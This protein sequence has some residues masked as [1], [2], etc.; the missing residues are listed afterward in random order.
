MKKISFSEYRKTHNLC[1]IMQVNNY[2]KTLR[3]YLKKWPRKWSNRNENINIRVKMRILNSMHGPIPVLL[4]RQR[5][6]IIPV[7]LKLIQQVVTA[8]ERY[9]DGPLHWRHNEPDGVSNHQPRDCLLNCLFRFRSKKKSKLRVTGLCAE[10][11]PGTGEFS[12]EM[13]S[14][15]ENVFIWWRHHADGRTAPYHD[16]TDVLRTYKKQVLSFDDRVALTNHYCHGFDFNPNM[17]K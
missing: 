3:L 14:N 9:I 8:I 11:S 1:C 12:A 2:T 6:W 10:N 15:A 13:A 17:D 5:I 16:T 4:F 7:T